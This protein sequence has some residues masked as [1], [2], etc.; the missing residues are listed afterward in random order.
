MDTQALKSKIERLDPATHPALR[1]ALIARYMKQTGGDDI[2]GKA[3]VE[4]LDQM[5][6]KAANDIAE[7]YVRGTDAHIRMHHPDL[8][9]RTESAHERLE[10]VWLAGRRGEASI[11]E[12]RVALKEWQGLHFEQIEV[13]EREREKGMGDSRCGRS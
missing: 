12:F 4:D 13:Y 6:K 3:Q 8:C 5:F 7:R 11:E 1:E 9:E 2:T 10:E